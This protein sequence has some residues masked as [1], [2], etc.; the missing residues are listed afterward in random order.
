MNDM[1]GTEVTPP[2]SKGGLVFAIIGVVF[3]CTFYLSF[4]AFPFCLTAWILGAK[5]V[6]RARRMGVGAGGAA[7]TAKVM[8]TIGTIFAIV[9]LVIVGLLLAV[10]AP[11]FASYSTR[12]KKVS[13]ATNQKMI[14]SAAA[15]AIM[16]GKTVDRVEGLV[17]EDNYL[18]EVPKCPAG[19][20][21]ILLGPSGEDDEPQVACTRHGSLT[22]A[23]R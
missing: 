13:C 1:N 7:I 22:G 9:S 8:G 15:M 10:A 11:N 16:S 12:S 3:L 19:G 5:A 2:N 23:L 4:L 6:N 20:T 21:Y 18:K 14:Q 17:G